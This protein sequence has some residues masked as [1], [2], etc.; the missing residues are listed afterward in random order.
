MQRVVWLTFPYLVLS[1]PLTLPF[2]F[3]VTQNRRRDLPRLLE[4]VRRSMHQIA[5]AAA[6]AGLLDDD[7]DDHDHDPPH[8]RRGRRR[9]RQ[10]RRGKGAVSEEETGVRARVREW[11]AEAARCVFCLFFGGAQEGIND[12][13]GPS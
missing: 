11:A 7:D 1:C 13:N 9:G 6:L 12:D 4:T 8:L 2:F 5:E 3:Y 10:Q